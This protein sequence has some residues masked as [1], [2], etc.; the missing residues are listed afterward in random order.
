MGAGLERQAYER[1]AWGRPTAGLGGRPPLWSEDETIL[2]FAVALDFDQDPRRSRRDSV[3]A[4]SDLLRRAAGAGAGRPRDRNPHGVHRKVARL[5]NLLSGRPVR[6][7]A[8]L[9]RA[10]CLRFRDDPN[11]LRLE[12]A[13]ATRRLLSEPSSEASPSRGPAPAFGATITLREDGTCYVY[14]ARLAG[15]PGSWFEDE[16]L[17]KFGR[18]TDVVRRMR[19]LNF[20]LPAPLG[21]EWTVIARYPF[22]SAADAHAV[23]QSLIAA[24]SGAGR[25]V[26]GE[27]VL[28]PR[29][30]IAE[31]VAAPP[32]NRLSGPPPLRGGRACRDAV[33]DGMNGRVRRR[34]RDGHGG[35][36]AR[37]D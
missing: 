14:L 24:E 28:L 12:V 22:A 27:F 37:R 4:L 18:T 8:A 36:R 1:Q 31:L 32:F 33:V 26:G 9:E 3:V 10:V 11:G 19:E 20:G 21:M 29:W 13:Q 25:S 2:A 5:E 35:R 23:E 6:G 17:C 7:G 16:T 34:G 30:R 15:V